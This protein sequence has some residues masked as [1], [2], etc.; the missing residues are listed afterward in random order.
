M[1]RMTCAL[2]SQYFQTQ[3]PEPIDGYLYLPFTKDELSDD[4]I[5]ITEEFKT[6]ST[7]TEKNQKF[8]I[9]YH[10]Q[11]DLS[12]LPKNAKLYVLGHG[13]NISP[14]K[15]LSSLLSDPDFKYDRVKH[16]SFHDW[17]YSISSKKT[18]ISID[19]VATRMIADGLLSAEDIHIKLWFCDMNYKAHGIAERF[20]AHLKDSQNT[21]RV[22]YYLNNFLSVPTMKNHETHKWGYTDKAF[23]N[24]TRASSVRESLFNKNNTSSHVTDMKEKTKKVPMYS[25][26]SV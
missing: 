6:N 22:D 1:L 26:K 20:I 4:M 9:L 21:Y 16:L 10:G 8:E 11:C 13:M 3:K 2:L 12:R 7:N 5:K 17:A 18:A 23:T 19:N 14:D 24:Y 25:L 15:K